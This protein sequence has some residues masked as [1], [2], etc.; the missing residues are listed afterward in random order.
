M[1]SLNSLSLASSARPSPVQG[2][3]MSTFPSSSPMVGPVSNGFNPSMGFQTGGIGMG[4]RPSGPGLYGGMASTTSTPNFGA[5]AQNQGPSGLTNRPPDMSALDNLFTPNKPKVS[6][7]QIGPQAAPGGSTPWETR[8]CV[9][10][11]CCFFPTCRPDHWRSRLT[12]LVV[13]VDRF[14]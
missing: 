7:N 2:T 4:M 14:R 10:K 3:T 9:K 12:D 13:F 6:L 1:T 8:R 11:I 5:L